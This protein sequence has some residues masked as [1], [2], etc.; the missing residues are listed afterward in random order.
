M[1]Y[2]YLERRRTMQKDFFPPNV[3]EGDE[4]GGWRL[5]FI[6][7]HKNN[8]FLSIYKSIRDKQFKKRIIS[9]PFTIP[10]HKLNS[11]SLYELIYEHIKKMGKSY[12]KA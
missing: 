12:V 8:Y 10:H 1:P 6:D 3:K 11:K 5:S 4:I 2:F 7:T 9:I